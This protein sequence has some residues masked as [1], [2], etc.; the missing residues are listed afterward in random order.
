M[1]KD[2]HA[3]VVLNGTEII[4]DSQYERKNYE[5]VFVPKSVT[6]IGNNAF[7]DCRNLKEVVFEEE[8]KLEKI[9]QDCF[10]NS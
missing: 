9:G 5:T 4:K 10:Q 3:L 1:L 2:P 8:S 6:E 7:E